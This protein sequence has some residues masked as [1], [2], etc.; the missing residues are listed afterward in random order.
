MPALLAAA[1]QAQDDLG[2]RVDAAVARWVR[3]DSPGVSI[4]AV[5]RGE[6]VFS[7]GY[8][9]ASLEHGTP[10]RPETVFHVASVSKQFTA[11]ALC[12]LE[13]EGALSLDDPVRDHLPEVPDF[14]APITLRHFLHHTSRGSAGR[15]FRSSAPNASSRRWA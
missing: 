1:A 9:L 10:I 7:D 14:G 4:A 8:G 5:H 11:F 15:H 3:D 2:S 13:A 12:L 6:V